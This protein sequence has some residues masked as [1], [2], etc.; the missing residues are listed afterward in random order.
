MIKYYYRGNV[1]AYKIHEFA[2]VGGHV[3]KINVYI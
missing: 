3:H 2:V 1:Q